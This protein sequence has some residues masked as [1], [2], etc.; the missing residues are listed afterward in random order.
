MTLT[1]NFTGLACLAAKR[2]QNKTKEGI[3]ITFERII[4]SLKSLSVRSPL[5]LNTTAVKMASTL[6]YQRDIMLQRVQMKSPLKL[7]AIIVFL[8]IPEFNQVKLIV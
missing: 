7:Q 4:N 8:I 5:I 1:H 3:Y 2:K 6:Y